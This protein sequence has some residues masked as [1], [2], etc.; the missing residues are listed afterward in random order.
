MM[1]GFVL[2]ELAERPDGNLKDAVAPIDATQ[3]D[4]LYQFQ[5]WSADG[6]LQ[7]RSLNSSSEEPL[8]PLDQSGFLSVAEGETTYRVHSM[9]DPIHGFVVQVAENL[10]HRHLA[11]ASVAWHY[12]VLA[13]LPFALLI[14][15]NKWLLAQTM[16]SVRAIA[17]Q[18]TTRNPLDVSRL[19]VDAPPKEV[20]PILHSI[21]RLFERTGTALCAERRFTSIAAHEMRTPLAGIRAQAQLA[22]K[23]ETPEEAR[24]ALQA[25][26]LGVDR[27]SHVLD[28]LL[29]MAR[30][31]TI[32][33]TD[34]KGL[35]AVD[36]DALVQDVVEDV[37]P[38]AASRSIAITTDIQAKEVHGHG[39]G[40][41]L[42]LRNLVVNGL[43][44]GHAD[45]RLQV[46]TCE[47]DGALVLCVDDTGPGIPLAQRQSAFERFN[48]L[49]RRQEDGGGAGLGLSI[50]LTV[51]E[52]HQARIQ[53]LDSPLGG[54]RA[55][56][57]FRLAPNNDALSQSG[58]QV[59]AA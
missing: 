20:M 52:R 33:A 42:A 35:Q 40:L 47:R 36:L 43:R 56:I 1:D 53:L 15:A 41:F 46:S 30:I 6:K 48:R 22:S 16:K 49:D 50:V 21:D 19:H 44:Y 59:V 58:V 34:D 39:F 27:S 25:L 17:A 23:A 12:I 54:L 24:E 2:H 28:Q 38:I 3:A 8:M 4:R 51:V 37:G 9:T 29:D 45:G 14:F 26:M 55:Q 11:L 18:L 13:L 10:A 32:F 7:L 57:S 5:V 31:E